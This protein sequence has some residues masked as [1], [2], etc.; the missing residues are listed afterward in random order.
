MEPEVSNVSR[1]SE[2][3]PLYGQAFSRP[4]VHKET[5]T[6]GQEYYCVSIDGIDIHLFNKGHIFI[7]GAVTDAMDKA[8]KN[9]TATLRGVW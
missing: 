9:C 6:L 4:H 3:K 5:S 2:C 1:R 7:I 8:E